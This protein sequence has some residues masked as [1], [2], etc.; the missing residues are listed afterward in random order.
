MKRLILVAGVL[1]LGVLL[2][3][4]TLSYFDALVARPDFYK[5]YSL[6]PKVGAPKTSPYY[7]G[8]LKSNKATPSGYVQTGRG[9]LV[10]TLVVYDQTMDAAKIRI[11]TWQGA[12]T[13]KY[14][15]TATDATLSGLS[16]TGWGSHSLKIE[17]E[18]VTLV[19][20]GR[21]AQSVT[22]PVTGK[23][24]TTY[25]HPMLRGQFGTVAAAHATGTAW[26]KNGNSLNDQVRVPVG[27]QNGHSYLIVWDAYWTD[28]YLG[29]S[30]RP[31]SRHKTFQ[32]ASRGI[33]IEPGTNYTGTGSTLTGEAKVPGFDGTKHV[34][35]YLFRGY[36][37]AAA[38]YLGE[39]GNPAIGQFIIWPNR[40]TR[41]W[42]LITQNDG[43]LP[44]TMS[45]WA[46][47][48]VQGVV[49]MHKDVLVKV[50][51]NKAGTA[52][53]IEEF[54][55]EYNTSTD[56]L[57][58]SR[59]KDERDFVSYVRNIAVLRDVPAMTIPSLLVKDG[60]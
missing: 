56:E 25:T 42:V 12:G 45:S 9:P 1:A 38:G 37:G 22:D 50:R 31:Q 54:Y 48:A 3:A 57:A 29:A 60:L 24:T 13:L 36:G 10:S 16:N 53:T 14:A 26:R 11:P 28:S 20:R 2:S 5:G 17:S 44:D 46:A 4:Q 30:M 59:A 41:T 52:R 21:T 6:R 15:L 32:L 27:T 35:A 40:W 51:L 47:D 39:H 33:W 34:A 18:I 55:L 49:Q 7:E 23:V 19:N 58:P 8:Q 43:V